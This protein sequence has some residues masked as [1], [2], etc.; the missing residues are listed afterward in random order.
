MA[1]LTLPV[2]AQG[3]AQAKLVLDRTAA[4]FEKADGIQADFSM[5]AFNKGIALGKATGTIRLKGEKFVLETSETVSWFDGK[6]QWSYLV[7]NDEVNISTPTEEELQ[8]MN[9]YSLLYLYRKGF[10]CRLGTEKSFGGKSVYEVVLVAKD[11]K[12][13]LAEIVLYVAE[14]TYEPVFI[15][16]EQRDGS[17]S[18]ITIARYRTGLKWTDSTFVFDKNKYPTAEVVDLR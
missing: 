2:L 9:P 6:T 7:Q 15:A 14:T 16:V 11:K 3:A 5:E 17:R 12:Q 1:L 13:P 18:E 4:A 8:G 10:D